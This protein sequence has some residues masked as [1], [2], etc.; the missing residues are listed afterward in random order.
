MKKKLSIM[1]DTKTYELSLAPEVAK[2]VE[3]KLKS[4]QDHRGSIPVL[5]LLESYLQEVIESGSVAEGLA[6]LEKK[7]GR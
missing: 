7:L 2:Q 5:K 3:E 4:L 6:Q 1:I